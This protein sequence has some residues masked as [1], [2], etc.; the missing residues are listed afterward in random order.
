MEGRMTGP[1]VRTLIL[2]RKRGGATR[3]SIIIRVRPAPIFA[4]EAARKVTRVSSPTACSSAGSI[5]RDTVRS[6]AK[7]G[8][9]A[10]G[11]SVSSLTRRT[12]SESCPSRVQ[13]VLLPLT[14]LPVRRRF[15]FCR[16]RS[17]LPHP[18]VQELS[19]Q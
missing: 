8:P 3:G 2:E 4:R 17:L 16:L 11:G 15:R 6:L 12:N 9:V 5:R 10:R 19:R 14:R 13:E 18:R 1:S 7:M